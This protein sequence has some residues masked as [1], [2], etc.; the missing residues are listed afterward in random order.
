MLQQQQQ[1]QPYVTQPQ[2]GYQGYQAPNSPVIVQ[3]ARRIASQRDSAAQKIARCIT[4]INTFQATLDDVPLDQQYE[5]AKAFEDSLKESYTL[6]T[7]FYKRLLDCCDAGVIDNIMISHDDVQRDYNKAL[8][9]IRRTIG[10]LDFIPAL[11]A[12][13][14]EVK[15]PELKWDNLVFTGTEKKKAVAYVNWRSAYNAN[16]LR[17][18]HLNNDQ[19]LFYLKASLKGR[20]LQAVEGYI[21]G[22]QLDD[23][24]EVLEKIYGQEDDIM[25]SIY[26]EIQNRPTVHSTQQPDLLRDLINFLTSQLQTLSNFGLDIDVGEGHNM[27]LKLMLSKLPHPIRERWFFNTSVLPAGSRTLKLFLEYLSREVRALEQSARYGPPEPP[28]KQQQQQQQQQGG[29][30]EKPKKATA[31]Q[32][33]DAL[34]TKMTEVFPGV[35]VVSQTPETK[36]TVNASQQKQAAKQDKQSK[37]KKTTPQ[38]RGNKRCRFCTKEDHHTYQCTTVADAASRLKFLQDNEMCQ[39]CGLHKVKQEECK[40]PIWLA[41]CKNPRCQYDFAHAWPLLHAKEGKQGGFGQK[42]GSRQQQTPSTPPTQMGAIPAI[43]PPKPNQQ[44]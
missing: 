4:E 29:E 10:D 42:Q 41:M 35:P 40:G 13:R 17:S 34:I 23:A 20:A 16:I 33:M 37:P 8:W 3:T 14:K 43:P 18:A 9:S 7:T 26:Q 31:A 32:K 2:Q 19:R 25:D 39:V 12:T 24:L 30:K 1:Q 38:F 11:E 22:H 28:Q 27:L 44:Q 6:Y 36:T 5:T 15:L 21:N